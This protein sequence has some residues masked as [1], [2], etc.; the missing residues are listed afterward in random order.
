MK[1][2]PV[3]NQQ[4]VGL[5]NTELFQKQLKSSFDWYK[6]VTISAYQVHAR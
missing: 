6:K 3:E 2:V 5:K 1:E 4:K